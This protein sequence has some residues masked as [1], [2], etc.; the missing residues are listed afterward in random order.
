MAGILCKEHLRLQW[1][2]HWP[3]P[4][5]Q[6]VLCKVS[7]GCRQGCREEE[8]PPSVGIRTGRERVASDVWR[9]KAAVCSDHPLSGAGSWGRGLLLG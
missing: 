9:L 6:S 3:R 2:F 5:S 1:L 7:W 4:P 8:V